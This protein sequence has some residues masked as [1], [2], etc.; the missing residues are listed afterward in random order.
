[1]FNVLLPWDDPLNRTVCVP[2]PYERVDLGP[3]INIRET[4]FDGKD[5]SSRHVA[6]HEN[7]VGVRARAPNE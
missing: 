3:F 4:R 6:S 5:Y 7:N 1:M 2:E